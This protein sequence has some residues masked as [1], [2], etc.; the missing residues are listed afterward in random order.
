MTEKNDG[1]QTPAEGSGDS[2]VID[3]VN[4]KISGEF[5]DDVIPEG[6]GKA[7]F[8]YKGNAYQGIMFDKG[9]LGM[10]YMI[11]DAGE[12]KFFIYDSNRDS[13]YYKEANLTIGEVSSIPAYQYAGSE[14]KEIVKIET[15][16]GEQ[17]NGTS[18]FYILYGMDASGVTCWY[19]Y[20]V[21]QGT[22]QRFNEEGLVASE[23]TEDYEAL[24]KSYKRKDSKSLQNP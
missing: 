8:E 11:N 7:D 14:E 2:V 9:Y 6:F 17:G 20:D 19:Q 13:F 22:Y 15:E 24:S 23:K 5:S 10:Y 1:E 12:G 18:D 16:D 4:Y 21:L 3:G